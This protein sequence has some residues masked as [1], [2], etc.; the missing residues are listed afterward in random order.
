MTKMVQHSHRI[1]RRMSSNA[2][3]DTP[4]LGPV[5]EIKQSWLDAHG[6]LAHGHYFTVFDT[7]IETALSIL[8]AEDEYRRAM[9]RGFVV[10]LSQV[11]FVNTIPGAAQVRATFRLV[12]AD[13]KSLHIYLELFHSDGWL[14]ATA[15]CQLVHVDLHNRTA[16]PFVG[17]LAADVATMLRYHRSLPPTKHMGRRVTLLGD[18]N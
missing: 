2:S 7:A 15:E 4:I 10:T 1:D 16:V 9:R 3:F 5:V 11:I 18:A 6:E 17:E 13:D 12:D 14:A 8:N